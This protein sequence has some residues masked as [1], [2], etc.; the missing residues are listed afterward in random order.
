MKPLISV[1]MPMYNA[2]KYLRECIDSVLSQSFEDFEFLIVDDGS[3]D[4]SVS[5][6]ESYTDSRIRLIKNKHDYIGS[7]N[8]LLKRARGKYIARMD[9]DDVMMTYRLKAQFGYM[10]KHTEVGVL[11]GGMQQI[12]ERHGILIPLRKVTIQDMINSCCIAH[13]SVMIRTS[14]FR[15]YGLCYEEDFKYAEDY[16][17]WIQMMKHEIVFRNLPVPVIRYRVSGNQ[18]TSRHSA[19]QFEKSI[20]IKEDGVKWLLE[21][22]KK[23]S[24][25]SCDIPE[26]TN[27]LTIVIPFLNEQDEVGNTV[28]SIRNTAGNRVD[29]IV[30]DD[31]SDDKY[32]YRSDL[33]DFN[34]TYIYNDC[35]IGAAA[36]KEKGVRLVRTPYFLL[37]DAHMRCFSH[38]WHNT[39]VSVLQKND[40]QI[41]CC[42][43]KAL[44]KDGKLIISEKGVVPTDGAYMLFDYNEYIPG[45]HW[46]DSEEYG[47]FQGNKIACIL[48]AGYAASKRYWTYLK[49]FEGLMHYGSEEAYLSL[50]AWLEGGGCCLLPNVVFGHIYRAKP[51][52]RIVTAQMHYNLFVISTTL[53]PTSL[54]CWANAIAYGKDKYIYEN[55]RFWL[56]MNK[57]S[58][59][60][61]K[62]YYTRTFH[63]D[64]ETILEINDIMDTGKVAMANHEKKRIPQLLDFVLKCSC[65]SCVDL[66]EGCMGLLIV[67]CEYEEYA[68][69]DEYTALAYE[70]LKR[71]QSRMTPQSELPISFAHGVCGIGWGFIY[72][73]RNNLVDMDFSK[74][75]SVIDQ[76]VMERD[77]KR[78]TDFSFQSGIGGILCYVT[79]RLF[80]LQEKRMEPTFDIKYL[81]CLRNV[82]RNALEKSVDFRTHSYALLFLEYGQKEWHVLRP[83]WKDVID[84]PT[85]LPTDSVKWSNGLSGS[86]GYLCN[87]IRILHSNTRQKHYWECIP[88]D[89]IN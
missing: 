4:D 22:V 73:M 17:L 75:L 80:V 82:A 35:R 25:E 47:R 46:N 61:L 54:Q 15:Q 88:N 19:E 34:V 74:E 21:R 37:L 1:C 39:I 65:T 84:L 43:T 24:Y 18:I 51:P 45:I 76:K 10:E 64:F 89:I 71:I 57:D 7:L 29:V 26:S 59:K 56:S 40:R 6:V 72:I 33:A 86:V 2:S 85:F 27:R 38:D 16:R 66:W 81:E 63:V 52:Y 67:L 32:D 12:G 77:P 13:P 87:L 58:L 69:A 70:L 41:L 5:I 78:I 9:A 8:M 50:K 83:R 60:K 23:V 14:I 42:Q 48:G 53:F 55:I 20:K 31:H 11:G 79:N 36:S 44:E 30:V 3:T 62:L 49:G 68:G 28:R